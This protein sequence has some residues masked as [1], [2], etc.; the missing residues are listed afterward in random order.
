MKK[1]QEMLT[2][3]RPEG[4]ETQKLFCN[5][6]LN[7]VMGEPDS[8]GNYIKIIKGLRG[9][10][11]VVCFTAHHDTVHRK[12]G[13]Q[14]VLEDDDYF[15]VD[16]KDSSCLGADCTTGV[17]LI[18]GMI[19]A[20]VPG[21]YVVH[22]GE[23]VG[24]IGSGNLVKDHPKWLDEVKAVISFDRKGTESVITHQM[25]VRT[26]SDAFA[27]SLA[28][29]LGMDFLQPDN[30]GSYTDSNEYIGVVGECTNL[31][32]G[33]YHQHT[34][35]EHQDVL[36]AEELMEALVEADWSL[37]VFEREPKQASWDFYEDPFWDGRASSTTDIEDLRELV[38]D[39][40]E[41]VAEI[42]NDWGVTVDHLKD[43]IRGYYGLA[44]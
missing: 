16:D 2:Y 25:G 28:Q 27:N 30:T 23:E 17:W 26:A 37:L 34:A 20:K 10:A 6:Y 21:V 43:S 11:P 44:A 14:V 42:L 29:A 1:L 39:Y 40:P 38:R 8:H 5:K 7:P 32:V 15:Y 12:E 24:C 4:S 19:E 36:F 3:M 35:N 31:S 41:E 22:A 18:L 9:E 33:Y 13:I